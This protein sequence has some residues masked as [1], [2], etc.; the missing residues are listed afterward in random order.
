[1]KVSVIIPNYNGK[2][3][4]EKNLPMLFES[5]KRY[6]DVEIIVVD[7]GSTDESVKYLELRT[8]DLEQKIKILK[9]NK[10][11]GFAYSCNRGVKEAEGKIVIL[12]NNDVIPQ[13]GFL[14]PLLSHFRNKQVFAVGCKELNGEERGRGVGEF[15]NG[16][17]VHKRTNNQNKNNTL[18]V[19][20]GSGAF[21][22]DL[23]LKLGGF[24]E[25]YKPFYWEDID[26]SYQAQKAGYKVLFEPSSIVYHRHEQTIGR[27][28]SEAQIKTVSYRNSFIFIWKNIT[29][30]RLF[31]SH[32]L[33][34]PFNFIK[35]VLTDNLAFILGFF[36]A[37]RLIPLIVKKRKGAKIFFI[38]KDK[39]IL[40]GFQQE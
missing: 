16:F 22:K 14:E 28:Y 35:A 7:D 23:F 21:S 31:I 15:K 40:S 32:F 5:I 11:Y 20:G 33:W 10:N 17:L 13:K 9:N 2:K 38:K 39:E 1:M 27:F 30:T 29:D 34:L 12:L 36:R 19:S 4:L 8:K 3:L 18:W 26:L 24:D 37:L 25:I 6:R